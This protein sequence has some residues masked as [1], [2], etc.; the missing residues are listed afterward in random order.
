MTIKCAYSNV[1]L[2]GSVLRALGFISNYERQIR[3]YSTSE[4]HFKLSYDFRKLDLINSR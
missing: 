2:Q 3:I 1:E 4:A